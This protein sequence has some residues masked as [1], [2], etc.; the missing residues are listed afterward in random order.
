MT[1]AKGK[2]GVETYTYGDNGNL[3]KK[4]LSLVDISTGSMSGLTQPFVYTYGNAN[5][6]GAKHAVT[7]VTS[8]NTGTIDYS[9]DE[10]GNMETRATDTMTYNGQGKLKQIVTGGG[11]TFE[12]LYDSTG[13]RIRK[14]AKNSGVITYNFDGLYEITKTGSEGV[15]H[16][17]Y[18]KGLYGD[19][20]AQMTRGDAVLRREDDFSSSKS[21]DF[22]D[23]PCIR[24]DSLG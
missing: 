1:E 8:P 6:A 21:S 2:Y 10:S 11:D 12:Y 22:F 15:P 18:F 4:S 17:L 13:N 19:V 23:V 24:Q 5:H 20:F 16:T 14:K 9:Y 3:M 7:S